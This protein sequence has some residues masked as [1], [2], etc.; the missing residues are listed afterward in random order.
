[1]TPKEHI[2]TLLAEN[3]IEV[4]WHNAGPHWGGYM[5]ETLA[6]VDG[7]TKLCWKKQMEDIF[8]MEFS[9]EDTMGSRKLVLP[10]T[11]GQIAYWTALHEIGHWMR[12]HT[13][14]DVQNRTVEIECEAWLWARMHS[15]IHPEPVRDFIA[16][17]IQNYASQFPVREVE[18]FSN[19]CRA[20]KFSSAKE[21]EDR[22]KGFMER[23]TVNG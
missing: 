22:Y 1:M 9:I 11:E 19:F 17:C 5:C 12:R 3:N 15:M 14:E 4:I 18:L 6:P 10:R 8:G 2:D 7:F 13:F 21:I 23:M 16:F 20:M